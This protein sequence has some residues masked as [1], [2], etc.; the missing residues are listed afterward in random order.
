MRVW[1]LAVQCKLLYTP[2]LS[3][4]RTF[5]GICTPVR[6]GHLLY[7]AQRIFPFFAGGHPAFMGSDDE[8]ANLPRDITKVDIDKLA[9][10]EPLHQHPYYNLTIG[11]QEIRCENLIETDEAV[12]MRRSDKEARE[13]LFTDTVLRVPLPQ[14]RRGIGNSPF[15]TCVLHL[16]GMTR[17]AFQIHDD[18]SWTEYTRLKSLQRRQHCGSDTLS[19]QENGNPNDIFQWPTVAVILNLFGDE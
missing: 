9:W 12:K 6:F 13:Y 17:F 3:V 16:Y 14:A 1:S 4:V 8:V 7:K 18:Q 15:H 11:N 2:V 19:D 5:L 10:G